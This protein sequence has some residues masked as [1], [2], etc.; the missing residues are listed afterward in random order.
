MLS[1]IILILTAVAVAEAVAAFK[2]T[3]CQFETSVMIAIVSI[4]AALVLL[5]IADSG[6]IAAGDR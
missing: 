4:A 6:L 3:G 1:V 5:E 2:C